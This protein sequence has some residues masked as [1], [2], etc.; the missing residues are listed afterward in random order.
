MLACSYHLFEIP[1][2]L[3]KGFGGIFVGYYYGF[4]IVILKRGVMDIIQ[5]ILET[6]CSNG[7]YS[8]CLFFRFC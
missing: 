2:D 5:A 1:S 8:G 3:M 7:H 4:C 6:F